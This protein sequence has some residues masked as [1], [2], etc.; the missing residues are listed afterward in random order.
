MIDGYSVSDYPSS[1][2]GDARVCTMSR[3]NLDVG[4]SRP[5]Y[6]MS[7]GYAREIDKSVVDG[8]PTGWAK[9]EAKKHIVHQRVPP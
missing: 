5:A 4:D 1:M 7:T 3:R 6:G 8:A 9:Y 2:S